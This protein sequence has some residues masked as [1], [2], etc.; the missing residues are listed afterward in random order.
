MSASP[1]GLLIGQDGRPFGSPGLRPGLEP[2]AGG[3][4]ARE[5]FQG[6]GPGDSFVGQQGSE[7]SGGVLVQDGQLADSSSSEMSTPGAE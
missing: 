4:D 2:I 7:A 1:R 6:G 5:V 3:G